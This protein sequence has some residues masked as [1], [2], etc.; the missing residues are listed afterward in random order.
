M[1][2]QAISRQEMKIYNQKGLG[3]QTKN[4]QTFRQEEHSW[5]MNKKIRQEIN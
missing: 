1:I 4:E 5:T 2:G 3:M